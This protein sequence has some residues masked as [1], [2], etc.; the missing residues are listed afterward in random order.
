MRKRH[1]YIYVA[2]AALM[3]T[4]TSCERNQNSLPM[5][6][7][8]Y[9]PVVGSITSADTKGTLYNPTNTS[10]IA[11]NE[12]GISN[13]TVYGYKGSSI[14]TDG[15]ETVEYSSSWTPAGTTEVTPAKDTYTFLA[16]AN[17]TGNATISSISST[18]LT[19]SYSM[20]GIL[21][22]KYQNDFLVGYFSKEIN[23]GPIE[24]DILFK[25]PLTSVIFRLGIINGDYKKENITRI[26]IRGVHTSGTATLTS[27]GTISWAN[28]SP[29]P[30][31]TPTSLSDVTY[32]NKPSTGDFVDSDY[33]IG[34][35][36]ILLPQDLS[37]YPVKIR[38]CNN[39]DYTSYKEATLSTGSW[40]P[41]KTYIYSL[42][43]SE[44]LTL[45]LDAAEWIP[46]GG[47]ATFK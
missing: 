14:F 28:L 34:E 30:T 10:T 47:D 36:F 27:G 17:N 5:W 15:G 38:L 42:T 32:C 21:D 40:E 46:G 39:N 31:P 41:G 7:I 4:T 9:Q 11:L 26:E 2:A 45:Y 22:T 25:H 3:L 6:S 43:G 13:F 20:S 16:Y 44:G 8:N 18:E 19:F 12:A 24:A 35:P 29:A 23:S 33:V 37:K 1:S